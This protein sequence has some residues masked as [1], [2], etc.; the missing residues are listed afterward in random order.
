MH[1]GVVANAWQPGKLAVT[2]AVEVLCRTETLSQ[3]VRPPSGKHLALLEHHG[4]ERLQLITR[5]GVAAHL[6]NLG[7]PAA[8]PA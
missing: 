4:I 8:S 5:Q 2:L 1:I 3:F 7:A 6:L